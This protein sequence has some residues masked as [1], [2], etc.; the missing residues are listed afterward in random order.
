[1]ISKWVS[2]LMASGRV[3]TRSHYRSASVLLAIGAALAVPLILGL[4]AR[5]FAGQSQTKLTK[6]EKKRQKELQKEEVSPYKKWIDEEVPYIITPQ[7]RDAFKKLTTDD[8]R[9]SFIES[10]W[11][12]RNPNPGD[13]EN[14][15][16]EEYYRRIAYANEHFASGVPGWKTDRGR[17]YIMYGPPNEIDNHDSGG[18]YERP[19]EEG[20]GETSTFPF[21]DWTYNYID[22]IGNNIKLEFV[23]PTM[24]GEFHLTMD[25]GEKD[26][27]L[28]VP[29]AGLTLLESMGMASKSD[30]FT[31][32]DGMTIGQPLG[33]L[34]ESMEEFTRLDTFAKIFQPPVVK[35]DDLRTSVTH[36][37]S[38][39]VLP[40]QVRTDFVRITEDAVLTP[41]TVQVANKDLQF[42]NKDGV[43]HAAL[44]VYGE[45]TTPSGRVATTFEQG[46]A[47]DMPEHDFQNLGDRKEVYQRALP[48]KPGL[49]KLSM[50]LKDENSGNVGYLDEGIRVPRY[51]DDKLSSSSLILADLIQQVPTTQVGT[52]MFVI[53]STKVR[54]SVQKIFNRDQNLGIYM[55]VYNLSQDPTTHRPSAEIEYSLVKDGK[56]LYSKSEQ[57]QTAQVTISKTLPLKT[58]QPGQY[59]LEVKVTDNVS[60]QSVTQPATFQL[61]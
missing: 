17:I 6:E 46:V 49:Y 55:Q 13:P 29:N 48:L 41:I 38:S 33:G 56:S 53:G 2:E 42:Q 21:E 22:G 37:I 40:F 23:D 57:A 11:E 27:L 19:A 54:P 36:K 25:P 39:Q 18:T 10:F 47:V 20:G 5:T 44:D 9:E 45:L 32:T 7:E 14:E 4:T 34:P 35:F 60:K 30:R 50:V 51:E 59:T 58:L 1:M 43:M 15:F 31:R 3:K 8:E 26:A 16:K 24:S 28:H 61:Q 52:G 12:R